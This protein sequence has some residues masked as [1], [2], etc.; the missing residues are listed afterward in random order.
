MVGRRVWKETHGAGKLSGWEMVRV[1]TLV[2][3]VCLELRS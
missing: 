2:G 1:D 3:C